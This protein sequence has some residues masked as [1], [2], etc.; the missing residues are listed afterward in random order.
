MRTALMVV[1][2]VSSVACGG[3][4]ATAPATDT[5]P[6]GVWALQTYNGSSLP[7]T[8]TPIGNAVDKVTDGTI[9]FV[10][11]SYV[12]DITI[13]RT[14]G[15]TVFNQK[16]YEIGSYTSSATGVVLR[17]NDVPGGT[18]N[19]TFLP[20]AVPVSRSGNTISFLQ[21]GKILTFVKR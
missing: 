19:T 4:T 14:I 18:G 9:Q 6:A 10:A 12:I 17:P 1:A 2:L 11:P 3:A 8:G 20:D 13:I 7:Y 5:F 16:Y 21:K 15:D